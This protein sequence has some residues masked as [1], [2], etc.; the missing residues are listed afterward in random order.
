VGA[1]LVDVSPL[2]TI[3]GLCIAAV[4]KGENAKVLFRQLLLWGFAMSI[5]GALFAQF[6]VPF[7][8]V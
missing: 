7:F 5:V 1:A 2:S 6:L 8:V 4:P 3:G